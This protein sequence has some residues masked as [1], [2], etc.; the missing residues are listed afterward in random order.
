MT[1]NVYKKI[2]PFLLLFFITSCGGGGGEKSYVIPLV[3]ISGPKAIQAGGFSTSGCNGPSWN[4]CIVLDVFTSEDPDNLL[5]FLNTSWDNR[6]RDPAACKDFV[7]STDG[8]TLTSPAYCSDTGYDCDFYFNYQRREPP[9]M[10]IISDSA[11]H[12]VRINADPCTSSSGYIIDGYVSGA[13]VFNDINENFIHDDN[14]PY[15]YS[16]IIDKS[17]LFISETKIKSSG[18]LMPLVTS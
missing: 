10:G 2:L 12:S 17:S 11:T 3:G 16:E 13:L 4:E 15:T 5:L 6:Y 18:N 14:E 9:G 7:I 1:N 8:L